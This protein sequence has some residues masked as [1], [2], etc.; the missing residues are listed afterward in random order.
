MHAKFSTVFYGRSEGQWSGEWAIECAGR[1]VRIPIGAGT[2]ALDWNVGLSIVGHDIEVKQTYEAL[3]AA[4]RTLDLF[5]DIGANYGTHTVCFAVHDV[6][7]LAFEPSSEARTYAEQLCAANG[8]AVNIQPVALG[9][10]HATVT[11]TYPAGEIWLAGTDPAVTAKLQARGPVV[12]EDVPQRLLDDFFDRIA[13][14]RILMKLDT[15][16]REAQVLRGGARVLRE[17]RPKIVFEC[18]PGADRPGVL[19]VLA[20]ADYKIVALPWFGGAGDELGAQAFLTSVAENFMALPRERVEA[21]ER[22]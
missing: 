21:P 13:P 16:G 22:E 11:L 6:P 14:G 17:R 2:Q 19:E 15:E 10:R 12:R 9:D 18:R 20:E 7:V 4:D 3:L 1:D 5:I 8:R